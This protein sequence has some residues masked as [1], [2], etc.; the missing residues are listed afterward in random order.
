MCVP[1]MKWSSEEAALNAGISKYGLSKWSKI[2][3]AV[4]FA[5]V[6]GKRSMMIKRIHGMMKPHSLMLV[7]YA[8]ASFRNSWN[9]KSLHDKYKPNHKTPA[10]DLNQTKPFS[11]ILPRTTYSLSG[12]KTPENSESSCEVLGPGMVLLKNYINISD[13]VKIVNTCQEFGMGPRGFYQPGYKGGAK[14]NLHMMCFGRNWDPQTKY[15]SYY[16]SDG[17]QAPPVPDQLISLVESSIQD[18]QAHDDKIPSMYPD[19]CIINFYTTTGRLGLHQDRDE[20]QNS[21]NRGLPV[22]SISIG[23][24]LIFG[25]KSRHIYHGM[26]TIVPNSAPLPLVQQSMLRPGR[27]NLTFRQY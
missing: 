26:K 1:K 9:E 7:R 12:I 4:E 25:G 8:S 20:S 18:S 21:L 5:K 15:D 3:G 16:R 23:D 11:L 22:V 13:Q 27:L 6:L 10:N 14:L 24:V 2:R 17:S 19:I